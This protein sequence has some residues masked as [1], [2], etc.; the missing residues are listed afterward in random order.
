MKTRYLAAVLLTMCCIMA[1]V[2]CSDASNNVDTGLSMAE[3]CLDK[4]DYAG[5]S[6]HVADVMHSGDTASM[7]WDDYCR[8]CVVY[9]VCADRDIDADNNLAAALRCYGK[10]MDLQ[11]DSTGVYMGRL[12]MER[13]VS[14]YNAVQLLDYMVMDMDM[15]N[16]ADRDIDPDSAAAH[17]LDQMP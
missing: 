6:Q 1:A 14:V 8:A 16:M 12:P 17:H 4:G 9:A 3:D 5:A 7:Q 2:S 11:P 15:D 13:S 10:A